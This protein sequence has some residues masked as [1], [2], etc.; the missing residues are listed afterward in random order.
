MSVF[1]LQNRQCIRILCQAKVVGGE[2]ISDVKFLMWLVSWRDREGDGSSMHCLYVLV[3][4]TQFQGFT[5]SLQSQEILWMKGNL[6]DLKED[7]STTA[8]L[9]QG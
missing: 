2:G 3:H 1:L 4:C 8:R 7:S 5:H 9:I 6:D